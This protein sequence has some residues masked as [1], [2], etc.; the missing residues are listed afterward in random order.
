MRLLKRLSL[1][2]QSTCS[3]L[4]ED[5]VEDLAG[6]RVP[7]IVPLGQFLPVRKTLA[8]EPPMFP[9]SPCEMLG[10]IDEVV[11]CQLSFAFAKR[12]NVGSTVLRVRQVFI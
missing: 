9:Q 7:K 12:T 3:L 5:F 10:T 6:L 1:P 2:K 8:V 11:S 4:L